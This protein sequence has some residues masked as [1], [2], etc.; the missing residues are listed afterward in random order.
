MAAN[1]KD[2]NIELL[3]FNGI[4]KSYRFWTQ[5]FVQHLKALTTAKVGQWLAIQTS[6]PEPKIKF[7]DWLYGKP[8]LLHDADESEQR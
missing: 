1:S 8:P 5:K 2:P 3:V 4:K 6:R 7:E